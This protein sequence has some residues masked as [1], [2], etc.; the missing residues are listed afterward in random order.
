[1]AE[2]QESRG[3]HS[4][5]TRRVL[6]GLAVVPSLIALVQIGRIALRGHYGT[7]EYTYAH[8]AWAIAQGQEPYRDFL[9][10]HFPLVM[11]L[12]SLVFRID[13]EPG[14]MQLLRWEMLPV[15]LLAA[16]SAVWIG[17]RRGVWAA[18][19]TIP[20]LAALRT[21]VGYATQFRPDAL[22]IALFFLALG[23]VLHRGRRAEIVAGIAWT[24]A[25]WAS[26]KVLIYGSFL[27]LVVCIDDLAAPRRLRFPTQFV[28][29]A[30]A[31]AVPIAAYLTATH[32][33]GPWVQWC[34]DW[35]RVHERMH[36]PHPF[37]PSVRTTVRHDWAVLALAAIGI[38]DAIHRSWRDR[39]R[40]SFILLSCLAF[41]SIS[42]A[43]QRAPYGWSLLPTLTV[44]A[45]L[46]A[47]AVGGLADRM[48][49]TPLANVGMPALLLTGL[50]ASHWPSHALARKTNRSQRDALAR[51]AQVTAPGDPVYD[52]TG[53]AV[54][55]PHVGFLFFTDDT[56]RRAMGDFLERTVPRDILSSGVTV[57]L[58]D[59]KRERSLPTSV[60]GFLDAHFVDVGGDL[61]LWGKRFDLA[62][63]DT[64]LAT[65]DGLYYVS[66]A[67]AAPSITI[68]GAPVD[69]DV[70]SLVRGEHR[71]DSV[72]RV[73]FAILWLPRDGSKP[74]PQTPKA[75]KRKARAPDSTPQTD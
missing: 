74:S 31:A 52:N 36:K 9:L 53:R 66:P 55:R 29:G 69:S 15:W 45:M 17:S 10:H 16:G 24:A 70:F 27:W 34:Y 13:D 18:L 50:Y 26:Q 39:D 35:G 33:W 12:G 48:A 62:A 75:R 19:A 51:I 8:A 72:Q 47:R 63:D 54:A 23:C 21:W 60:R 71:I 41:A 5:P 40:D 73:P 65:R 1:M 68:D 22:A 49:G 58:R 59:P 56:I 20:I 4:T 30:F 3:K 42:F 46:A 2:A 67:D 6:V 25:V 11:Q 38:A 61:R 44:L 32:N 43:M 14:A 7:D 37:W 64:F 57:A 28:A